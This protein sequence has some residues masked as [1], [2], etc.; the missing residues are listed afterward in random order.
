MAIALTVSAKDRLPRRFQLLDRLLGAR[1]QR[2]LHHRL[3]G[4]GGAPGGRLQR[5]VRAQPPLISTR[6]WATASRAMKAS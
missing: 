4:T 3:L 5:G 1:I 2:V 6:P